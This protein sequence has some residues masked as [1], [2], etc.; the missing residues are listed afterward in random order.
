MNSNNNLPCKDFN[1]TKNIELRFWKKV[2]KKTK[3]ECWNWTAY[4]NRKGYA[5]CSIGSGISTNASRVSWVIHHGK[6]SDNLYV[7]HKCDNRA[8]VNPNHLFLGT[9]QENMNDATMKKRTRHFKKYRF[10]GVRQEKRYDGPNRKMSWRSFICKNGKILYMNNHTSALE[11]ARNYDR[12]A[13]IVFGERKKLNFPE[14]Y[15][16]THWN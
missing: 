10:F 5:R 8:C 9:Q 6:I 15:E 14:Q 4:I 12:I 2:D 11:A 16:I 3:D 13:Y 7:C 1:L